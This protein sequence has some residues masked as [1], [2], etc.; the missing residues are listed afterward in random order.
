MMWSVIIITD[1]MV[2]EVQT[3]ATSVADGQRGVVIIIII[4]KLALS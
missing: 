4:R 2:G 3:V 1:L